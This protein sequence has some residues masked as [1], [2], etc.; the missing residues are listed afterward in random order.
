MVKH[1]F[2]EKTW[3]LLNTNNEIVRIVKAAEKPNGNWVS[4]VPEFIMNIYTFH[5]AGHE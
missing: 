2:N 1:N 3:Y 4:K 5:G